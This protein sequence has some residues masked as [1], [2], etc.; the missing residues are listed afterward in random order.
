[1]LLLVVPA[2][3]AGVWNLQLRIDARHRQLD[4]GQ[5]ALLIP[6]PKLVRALSLEYKPLAADYY[7]TRTV[8]YYGNKRAQHDANL[9]LL[10]PLLDVTTQLDPNLIVA[11]RFGATFLAEPQPRGAGRPD[12]AVQLIERG[13]Q[14]NP[15]YW[16]LYED[17][18]FV[19]YFNL[20]D[21]P[22]A[23]N[24]FLEGSKNPA[25]MVWMKILAA[26]IMEEGESPE[27]SA[28]LWTEV[29]NSSTDPQ[30][31][32]NALVHLQLLRVDQDIAALNTLIAEFTLR[33]GHAPQ[34]LRELVQGGRL[35]RIPADPRGFAYVI[36]DGKAQLDPD[37]PL[38]KERSIYHKPLG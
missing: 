35:R 5:E 17:L 11:Y 18:G 34:S 20:K 15:D 37:S 3:A 12:L 8:Q 38:V 22:N 10:W 29:Y 31:R 23:A 9:N 16:R 33:N 26:K 36:S 32:N 21:Y 2:G 28:F 25:S 6:S 7:W 1:L 14:A 13:I 4:A 19:Y 27:T 24:A 30:I